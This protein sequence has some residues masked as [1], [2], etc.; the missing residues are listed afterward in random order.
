MMFD[1]GLTIL[2]MLKTLIFGS[3]IILS[4]V[5][6]SVGIA[7]AQ[8]VARGDGV[9]V[10]SAEVN[11]LRQHLGKVAYKPN[12]KSLV[13]LAVQ[14]ELFAREAVSKNL[15]CPRSAEVEGFSRK[16][17]LASCYLDD[18]LEHAGLM[19]GAVES[20]YWAH[21]HDFKDKKTGKLLELDA[22][23]RRLIKKRIMAAKKKKIANE[24]FKLL[25]KKYN[26]VFT[27]S[28]SR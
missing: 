6:C 18:R 16:V 3:V 12:R 7:G 24:E 19:S 10:T 28:G 15:V 25:C 11:T 20:Y 1:A 22:R 5:A 27:G 8:V 4:L 21:W 13:D 17:L 26:V 9:V 14:N 2:R 23:L